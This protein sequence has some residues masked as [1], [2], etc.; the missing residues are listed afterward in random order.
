SGKRPLD[1]ADFVGK[2]VPGRQTWREIEHFR[3]LWPGKLLLKGI[4]HPADAG[5]AAAMG[6]DGVIGSNH[7]GRQ[8]D[9]APSAL[10][11]LP[12]IKAAVGNRIA[13][14]FDSGI[15]RGADIV[16]ARCLGAD[17]VFTGRAT[18]YGAAAAGAV[19]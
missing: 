1:V 2:Q 14:L 4:L 13:V 19:G 8:L 5:Q 15:R 9:R 18:L 11:M 17:Y 3:R 12:A 10:A 7:G 6:C 16:I